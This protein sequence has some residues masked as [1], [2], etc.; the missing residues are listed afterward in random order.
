[1]LSVH[2]VVNTY[3]YQIYDGYRPERRYCIVVFVN[4]SVGMGI[5]ARQN[6]YKYFVHAFMDFEI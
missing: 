2:S 5:H 1:M 3:C 6:T 4:R